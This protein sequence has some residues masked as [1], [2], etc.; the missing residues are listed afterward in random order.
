MVSTDQHENV[1]L[2][3]IFM[4]VPGFP[5]TLTL[6]KPIESFVA[7]CNVQVSMELATA[8]SVWAIVGCS[9]GASRGFAEYFL[10]LMVR[11]LFYL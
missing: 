8:R 1:W 6:R 5:E 7:I 10:Q 11:F 4:E 2:R 9:I 3:G